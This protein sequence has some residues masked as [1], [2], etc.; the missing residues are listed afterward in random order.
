MKMASLAR[1]GGPLFIFL[2]FSARILGTLVGP[3]ALCK[4]GKLPAVAENLFPRRHHHRHVDRSWRCFGSDIVRVP[5]VVFCWPRINVENKDTKKMR[6]RFAVDDV[7][8]PAGRT[9]DVPVSPGVG[10]LR[11]FQR[12]PKS[13]SRNLRREATATDRQLKIKISTK[14]NRLPHARE[15]G[16]KRKHC[17]SD[18]P[19]SLQLDSRIGDLLIR[20]VASAHTRS[21]YWVESWC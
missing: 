19:K 4:R 15:R 16:K 13:P 7:M 5:S 14:H 12:P 6:S 9:S 2:D 21:Y 1:D 11:A 17:R 10:L 8:L 20:Q 18:S 3:C